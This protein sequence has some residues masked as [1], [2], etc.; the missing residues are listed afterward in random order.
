MNEYLV[1]TPEGDPLVILEA[2]DFTDA[3]L[4]AHRNLKGAGIN[5]VVPMLPA[6]DH[7]ASLVESFTTILG[8]D[9]DLAEIAAQ[10]RGSQESGLRRIVVPRQ[11]A[12]GVSEELTEAQRERQEEIGG[13]SLEQSFR[14]MGFSESA[15][16][17]AARGRE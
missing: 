11:A 5:D 14:D 9:A 1:K 17:I 3:K 10:G 8:G 6:A 4:Y 12:G 16:K 2:A 7:E 15:A 13:G